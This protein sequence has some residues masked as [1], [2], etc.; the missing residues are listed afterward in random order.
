MLLSDAMVALHAGHSL[1][2]AAW[3]LDEGYL[4]LMPGMKHVW[5]IVLNPAPNAGNYIFS[6]EDLEASD[7]QDFVFPSAPIEAVVA[8]AA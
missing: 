5:K 7:W 3:T 4:V 8:E 6:V 2:R 1:C